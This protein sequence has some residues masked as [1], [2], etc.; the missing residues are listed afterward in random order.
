[1]EHAFH[2]M[3]GAGVAEADTIDYI[4]TGTCTGTLDGTG[5]SGAFTVTEAADTSGIT[6]AGGEYP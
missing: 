3:A 1:L 2:Y 6:L 4:F 5:F